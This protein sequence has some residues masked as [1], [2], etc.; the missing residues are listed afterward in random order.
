MS[1]LRLGSHQALDRDSTQLRPSESHS[2]VTLRLLRTSPDRP[3]SNLSRSPCPLPA[4]GS[5]GPP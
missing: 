5:P 1:G 4:D 3:R 2:L